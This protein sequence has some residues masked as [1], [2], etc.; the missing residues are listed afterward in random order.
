[1]IY[2]IYWGTGGT[3]GL[4]LDEIYDA[5]SKAGYS[6]KIFVSYYYPFF[7]GKK[8]FFRFSDLGH[9][10]HRGI[11]RKFIQLIETIYAF[12]YIIFLSIVDSPQIINFSLV[13]K[14]RKGVLFFLKILKLFSR[15]KLIITCHD[16]CPFDGGKKNDNEY[17]I[18]KK[19]FQTADYL[20]VHNSNSKDDLR[21][22][23]NITKNVIYHRFPIKDLSKLYGI[24]DSKKKIDFL[25]IG[26]LRYEKGIDF[27]LKAWPK[28]HKMNNNAILSISG[29]SSKKIEH[30]VELL[31]SM[32]VT[33]DL[34]YIPDDEFCKIVQSARYVVLPY[35]KGTNSGILSDVLSLG[36]EVIVSNI[37][38]FKNNSLIANEDMFISED[39]ADFLRMLEIKYKSERKT[40]SR[41]IV[42]NYRTEFSKEVVGLYKNLLLR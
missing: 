15:G 8:I 24:I 22:Y 19:I 39:E 9:C 6:Q 5:L 41:E 3:S 12:C 13:S 36:T 1:M 27:L 26:V 30:D 11:V 35:I 23:F 25:F 40:K 16:V 31:K 20:L 33:F 21:K 28:F 7:Y 17:K 29:F 18:R 4:Y 10:S 34:R 42:E 2:H 32:N 37:S 38:M 14:T